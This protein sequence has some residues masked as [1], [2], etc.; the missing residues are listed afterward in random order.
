MHFLSSFLSLLLFLDFFLYFSLFLS[1]L[2]SFLLLD[3]IKVFFYSSYWSWCL[4]CC[5]VC[6]SYS[7]SSSSFYSFYSHSNFYFVLFLSSALDKSTSN[8]IAIKKVTRAFDDAIDAKRIL[9]EIKLMKKF[10]HENVEK[11]IFN[12]FSL[13]FIFIF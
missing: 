5:N 13:Y 8:K 7:Y 4:W 10:N 2:I 9:R 3:W 1:F 11:K 6:F 12:F